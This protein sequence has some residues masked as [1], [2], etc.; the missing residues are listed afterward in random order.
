MKSSQNKT[1]LPCEIKMKNNIASDQEFALK[2]YN[3][4]SELE[5]RTVFKSLFKTDRKT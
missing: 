3:R 1:K 4:I 2:E 5:E